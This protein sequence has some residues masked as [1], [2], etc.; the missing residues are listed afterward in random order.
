M[1]VNKDNTA[2]ELVK[3]KE[4]YLNV[5]IIKSTV[6]LAQKYIKKKDISYFLKGQL[7]R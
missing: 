5:S 2:I 4:L 1:E 6:N 7:E 3:S